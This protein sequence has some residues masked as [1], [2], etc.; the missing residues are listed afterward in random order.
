MRSLVTSETV[1]WPGL[2]W[3]TLYCLS[4]NYLLVDSLHFLPCLLTW[5]SFELSPLNGC[6]VKAGL[7]VT[8][9]YI[10]PS[11]ETSKALAAQAWI[12]Q[13]YLRTIHHACL[14]LVSVHPTTDY[15]RRHLIAAY[16][17]FIDP[18]RMNF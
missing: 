15:G 5:V 2:I 12:T 8:W 1:S 18:E 11:R 3:P 13:F 14:C 10:A 17:S 7:K 9:I 6:K 16:Y 4:Y